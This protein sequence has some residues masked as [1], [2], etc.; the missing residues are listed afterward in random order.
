[1]RR[2][3]GVL[4]VLLIVQALPPF[5]GTALAHARPV[6]FDPAPGAVLAAAPA[7]IQGWFSSEIR[8]VP[9]SF[10]HVLDTSGQRID[11]GETQLSTDRRQMTVALRPGLAPGRYLVNW[12]AN[13][14]ADG[15]TLAGCYVFFVGE[16]AAQNAISAG[17]PLD[18]GSRCPAVV[19]E[20]DE[21]VES[22]QP[23][24]DDSGGVPVWALAVGVIGGV[25]VGG[26]GG[27]LLG[28]S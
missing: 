27:R 9:D 3:V 20:E 21:G 6:R 5:A 19:E 25:V 4:V 7:S 28:Q 8:R 22:S 26:I 11:V 1:M 13:D 18:G 12:S 15:H 24:E 2:L 14:D 10:L 23:P 16:A 17:D